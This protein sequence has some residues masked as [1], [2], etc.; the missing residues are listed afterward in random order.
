[1]PVNQ[2][3][4]LLV[5][6]NIFKNHLK[7]PQTYICQQR[8]SH[9][10]APFISN[11]LFTW[12]FR[13]LDLPTVRYLSVAVPGSDQEAQVVVFLPSAAAGGNGPAASSGKK[14][15]LLV[16]VYG[17]P[18]F[19]V[20]FEYCLPMFDVLKEFMYRSV[21]LCTIQFPVDF[22]ILSLLHWPLFRA[23]YTV[24]MWKNLLHCPPPPPTLPA[25]G[26]MADAIESGGP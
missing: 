7:G 15:P 6:T 26:G 12:M 3:K 9:E 24:E 20:S 13:Q 8:K 16:D 23:V 11:L 19:Q 17:G 2:R 4:I 5:K 10:V 22:M 25:R 1:M 14:F 21:P 18:G